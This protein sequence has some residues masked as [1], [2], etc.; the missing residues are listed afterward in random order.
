LTQTSFHRHNKLL[1][2]YSEKS[3]VQ[4]ILCHWPFNTEF[5]L[6]HECMILDILFGNI[7]Y[8]FFT[9][10][11]NKTFSVRQNGHASINS[12]LDHQI[13]HKNNII[14]NWP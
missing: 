7:A 12:L 4:L 5:A 11:Y 8:C 13:E 10:N 1:S 14:E 6:S 2:S 3:L 9:R